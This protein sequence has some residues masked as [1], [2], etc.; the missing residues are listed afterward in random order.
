MAY[1]GFYF[2]IDA[3]GKLV[4]SNTFLYL[5]FFAQNLLRSL[6]IEPS[7]QSIINMNRPFLHAVDVESVLSHESLHKPHW[8]INVHLW[9]QRSTV[10]LLTS[11]FVSPLSTCNHHRQ[12]LTPAHLRIPY[13]GQPQP[14]LVSQTKSTAVPTATL[15]LTKTHPSSKFVAA[16][17]RHARSNGLSG[18]PSMMIWERKRPEWRLV[19]RSRTAS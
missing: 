16:E 6:S 18:S 13:W 5:F 17:F 1:G 3:L 12:F 15:P 14:C 11:P 19:K 2:E 4:N 10:C 9:S 7:D 8:M